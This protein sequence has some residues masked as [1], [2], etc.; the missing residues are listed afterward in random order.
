MPPPP[1]KKSPSASKSS[2][3]LSPAS[4]ASAQGKS[5]PQRSKT[6]T[7]TRRK[8]AT[9]SSKGLANGSHSRRPS[10][11]HGS[12]PTI[13]PP[14][15]KRPVSLSRFAPA[16]EP[17]PP[18]DDD[19][20]V[21][22]SCL[23]NGESSFTGS[24]RIRRT[25]A[26]R[27]QYFTNE[28]ECAELTPHRVLCTR[29]RNYV[30][31]RKTQTYAVRPWEAHRTRCDQKPRVSEEEAVAAAAANTSA[32]PAAPSESEYSIRSG[33]KTEEERKA[34]LEGDSRAETVEPSRVLCRKCQRWIVL[35]YSSSYNLNNWNRHQSSCGDAVPSSRVTAAQGKIQLLNDPQVKSHEPCSVECAT[36]SERVALTD[37]YNLGAWVAHKAKCATPSFTTTEA[38]G[39]PSKAQ[40]GAAPSVRDLPAPNEAALRSRANKPASDSLGKVSSS[41]DAVSSA[42]HSKAASPSKTASPNKTKASK[43]G[44]PSNVVVREKRAREEDAD[45][46]DPN[47]KDARPRLRQR[48][49]AYEAP[50]GPLGWIMMPIK[51]FMKGFRQ[52]IDED[53]QSPPPP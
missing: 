26:E 6:P 4:T 11:S 51:A 49:E 29:C 17:T 45:D 35:S 15:A 48:T 30:N 46:A 25:E 2:A 22:E 36:C 13:S 23:T 21:T 5:T 52:S 39:Y 14:A 3:P 7:S 42:M 16:R 47:D 8:P 40:E 19:V 27:I 12:N 44:G 34:I 10:S 53:G 32:D 31:L 20:S 33:R 50:S 41:Q 43:D 1:V 24:T 38:I 9:P 18:A 37:D 28:P